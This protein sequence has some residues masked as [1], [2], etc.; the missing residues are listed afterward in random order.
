MFCEAS[1]LCIPVF[2]KHLQNEKYSILYKATLLMSCSFSLTEASK[3]VRDQFMTQFMDIATQFT[4][5]GQELKM[6]LCAAISIA[7]ILQEDTSE[8]I[9]KLLIKCT[10]KV[11]DCKWKEQPWFNGDLNNYCNCLFPFLG[12]KE[13]IVSVL[14]RSLAQTQ[15]FECMDAVDSLIAVAFPRNPETDIIEVDEYDGSTRRAAK[16]ESFT[17]LQ[18]QILKAIA[19]NKSAQRIG[20]ISLALRE[21]GL[22]EDKEEIYKVFEKLQKEEATGDE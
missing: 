3:E 8:Q 16:Q 9:V 18:Q 10:E 17:P 6:Q 19:D 13:L 11:E 7:R 12:N 21:A 1:H 2:L 20:N 14:L 15:G 4:T 22:P 5:S